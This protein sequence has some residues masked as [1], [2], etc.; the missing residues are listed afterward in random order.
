M[1]NARRKRQQFIN[2]NLL[3]GPGSLIFFV[4]ICFITIK[5]IAPIFIP[6]IPNQTYIKD[7]TVIIP[8]GGVDNAVN[9]LQKSGFRNIYAI[10]HDTKIK[11]NSFFTSFQTVSISYGSD[12]SDLIQTDF[13]LYAGLK[14][15]KIPIN[16]PR[17]P[18]KPMV[19]G[20]AFN[21]CHDENFALLLPYQLE[22]SL[23]TKEAMIRFNEFLQTSSMHQISRSEAF[24]IFADFHSLHLI[25]MPCNEKI[26]ALP[27]WETLEVIE[28]ETDFDLK[29]LDNIPK[30]NEVWK[31]RD[32]L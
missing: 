22:Y 20:Y 4:L 9:S 8:D 2:R 19:I 26:K 28:N 29:P 5:F 18:D 27:K 7:I 23:I 30:I 31:I 14:P 21:Q 16:I 10:S 11:A 25:L 24:R 1:L 13:V 17:L 15:F 32:V 6:V 12:S 3:S